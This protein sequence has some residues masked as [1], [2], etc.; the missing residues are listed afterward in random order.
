MAQHSGGAAV[1]T[2]SK[3]AAWESATPLPKFPTSK[4]FP[5][6][7]SGLLHLFPALH[8]NVRLAGGEGFPGS[9]LLE[10]CFLKLLWSPNSFLLTGCSQNG[11]TTWLGCHYSIPMS[12]MVVFQTRC[13]VDTWALFWI[14]G[15]V[16]SGSS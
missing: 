5:I 12:L 2:M 4:T 11:L 7:S 16:G 9:Q 15:V 14:S 13:L 8:H 3:E 6:L 1:I 10:S